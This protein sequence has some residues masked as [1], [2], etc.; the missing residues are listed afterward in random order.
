MDVLRGLHFCN[1]SFQLCVYH[2]AYIL[3]IDG[4]AFSWL[5]KKRFLV[6]RRVGMLPGM[7]RWLLTMCV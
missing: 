2:I 6:G 5:L 4:S 7:C 3:F 1:F